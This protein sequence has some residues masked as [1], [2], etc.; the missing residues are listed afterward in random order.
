M[1]NMPKIATIVA[2]VLGVG[3]LVAVGSFVMAA[4][5]SGKIDASA[6]ALG[7]GVFTFL[8]ALLM[9]V[10]AGVAWRMARVQDREMADIS[11]ER[12]ILERVNAEGEV[13]LPQ[14]AAELHT[15]LDSVKNAV[16]RVAGKNLLAGYVNW[17]EQKLYSRDAAA[18]NKAG[19]CPHCGGK[20]ELAGKGVIRCPYCGSEVFLPSD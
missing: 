15:N 6:T 2:A 19:T 14:L 12:D 1:V 3:W 5:A 20:L 10:F 18:L 17:D 11:L 9:F 4:H 13:Y 16:Y 8:P 7:L